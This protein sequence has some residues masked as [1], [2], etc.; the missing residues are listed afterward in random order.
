MASTSTKA[1]AT[2]SILNPVMTLKSHEQDFRIR[3]ISYFPDGQ[4]MVSTCSDQTV[5]QWDLKAG[6]EIEEARR[7]C[8]KNEYAVAVS[9]NG[10]W[11]VT[12]G[13]DDKTVELKAC[14]VETGIV[15]EFEGHSA[16]ISC[17]DISA[18]ST[19]LASGSDD[20][21]TRIWNME[22]G[23]L[24]AGPFESV[25]E[26]GAVGFS[27]DSKKFAANS[28]TATY[29]EVWDIQKQKLD[30]ST[31]C[32][33]KRAGA[34]TYAPIVWTNKNKTILAAF[35][36]P[37]DFE[38]KTI[39]EFD[40]ST[41][42]TVG[43]PFQ[44][45]DLVTD[46]AL[47]SDNTLL[48][49]SSWDHTINLWAFESRELL[50][51]FDV[52]NPGALVL[53][54]DSR[55]LAYSSHDNSYLEN[56]DEPNVQV[57]I[58]DIPPD[59]LAQART[60]ARK[61]STLNDHLNSD[62]TRRAPSVRR[63]PPIPVTP[64][65]QRLPPTMNPQQPISLRLRQ[66]FRFSP[67]KNAAVQLHNPL[68]VPATLPLPSS[69]GQAATRFEHFEIS[70]PPPQNRP[71]T[72][73]LRQHLPFLVPRHSHV[74]PVVEVA[75]GR[76]FTRLAAANL[77]EYRKVDDTRHPPQAGVPQDI[78]SSDN[79]SLPDVHWCK[80]F[81]CYYSCWSH[82]RLRMPPRWRLERVHIPRQDGTTNGSGSGTRGSG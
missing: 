69:L 36:E 27:R 44:H 62:A 80:A 68:D 14:E 3:S 43:T 47:S 33:G 10:R 66:L 9:R 82:G 75:P 39:F 74:P 78:D 32:N 37:K 18:D 2:K 61:K 54:P 48:A 58:C 13:G 23:K 26:V 50:A 31:E 38:T 53:S 40:A 4:R 51:S 63:R 15:K 24:V 34:I 5:R 71:V 7:V 22:T 57:Y 30:A 56:D 79:D 8:E 60:S 55:Q 70:S 16:Q 17:I 25:N 11:F 35:S 81:L 42:E 72:Q 1:A 52:Q 59:V 76:K 65:V 12:A 29:L 28:Y 49:S 19:L 64:M 73:S 77:P 41:L 67:R 6:K 46:L 21:T 20:K 45:T